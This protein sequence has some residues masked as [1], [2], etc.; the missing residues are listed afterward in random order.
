MGAVMS[1]ERAKDPSD[2]SN[3]QVDAAIENRKPMP[4][5]SSKR[6]GDAVPVP[7]L[8]LGT[9]NQAR[10]PLREPPGTAGTVPRFETFRAFLERTND[11][12]PM[13]WLIDG[14]VPTVG[15]VWVIAAPGSGKTWCSFAIAKTA[16]VDGRD[17]FVIEEEH[18]ERG[19]HDRLRNMAFP[20][21]CLDRI[22]LWHRKG[23]KVGDSKF[24]AL[25]TAFASADRPVAIFD[26][27]AAVLEGNEN[28]TQDAS[29]FVDHMKRLLT[30]NPQG[31]VLV[32]HHVSKGVERAEGNMAM[33]GRGSSAFNGAADIELRQRKVTTP[34]GSGVVK[35]TLEN[36]KSREFEDNGT[37]RVTLTLGTGEM[38]IE[39][40]ESPA[41]TDKANQVLAAIRG[42]VE[43]LT[44][45]EITNV[46][47]RRK[48][49]VG[50]AVDQL[51]E[52]GLVRREGKGFVLA[53][54]DEHL[55]ADDE[56]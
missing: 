53:K 38:E 22:R 26:C 50:K 45:T 7:A 32:L 19:L 37:K 54:T 46:V 23:L 13:S 29:R 20:D 17:V 41:D 48:D 49:D 31:L 3:D 4:R 2:L 18:S 9:G 56:P 5:R 44:K 43:P 55:G 16:A 52:Q 8:G 30:S 25:V 33:A 11:L 40:V 15:Q 35:F 6:S 24:N 10:S 42:S 27:L 39:A 1:D 28:E 47:K 36:T 14:L 21:E 34:R 12:P 51:V